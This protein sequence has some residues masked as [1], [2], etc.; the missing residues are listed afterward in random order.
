MRAAVVAFGHI[1]PTDDEFAVSALVVSALVVC[2]L[3]VCGR[4]VDRCGVVAQ[5]IADKKFVAAER[6]SERAAKRIVAAAGAFNTETRS[7]ESVVF[8]GRAFERRPGFDGCRPGLD[9]CSFVVGV[10]SRESDCCDRNDCSE[11]AAVAGDCDR[12]GAWLGALSS[13]VGRIKEIG[14]INVS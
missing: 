8:P 3:V 1:E 4:L 11:K 10:N 2:G 5:A 6:C 14:L 12:G 9:G 13:R 7:G